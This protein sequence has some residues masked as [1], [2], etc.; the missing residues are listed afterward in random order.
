[1]NYKKGFNF[2]DKINLKDYQEDFIKKLLEQM[3]G[4]VQKDWNELYNKVETPELDLSKINK[5]QFGI[6][7]R[8]IPLK[9]IKPL[10]YREDIL[11]IMTLM[12]QDAVETHIGYFPTPDDSSRV[13][14]A[15]HQNRNNLYHILFD[16][17][18]LGTLSVDKYITFK[19]AAPSQ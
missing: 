12:I 4:D 14:F 18:L 3:R 15:I 11:T 19:S 13:S 7:N 17:I 5:T 2:E 16:G 9:D 1:M 6:K 8:K 10:N